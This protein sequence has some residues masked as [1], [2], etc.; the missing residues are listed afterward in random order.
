MN[1][2][3]IFDYI[4]FEW[5]SV[6]RDVIRNVWVIILSMLVG[7]MGV[8]IAE[9]SIYIPEY[10]STAMLVVNVK[11]SSSVANLNI[12][13]AAEMTEVFSDV[14]VQPS[15]KKKA[16]EK[17]GEKNFDGQINAMVLGETNFLYVSVTSSTPE[18]AYNLLN[19]VL[20]AYPE[21]SENVFSNA[22]IDIVK[23]PGMPHGP[24]NTIT[25]KKTFAVA[26]I[27]A[28]AAFGAIVL[29]SVF[30]DTVKTEEQFE[31]S[32]DAKLVGTIPH[33][34]KKNSYTQLFKKNRTPLLISRNSFLSLNFTES[35]QKI[36]TR[37]EHMK[38][39]EDASVFS[40]VSV[41][42]NEGKTTAA[43][44]IAIMLAERGSKVLILDLD[45][46]K[47]ALNK[48]FD[49]ESDSEYPE[50][51]ELLSGKIGLEDFK[52][53]RF[54]KSSLYIAGNSNRY[55][56]YQEWFKD[57]K[58]KDILSAL[59]EQFDYI[60]VDTA[61]M[62]VDAMVTNI[63]SLTDRTIMVVRNDIVRVSSINDA[64]LTI[65]KVGGNL[66]GCIYNDFYSEF[67]LFGQ[68][69]SSESDYKSGRYYR[70]GRKYKNYG[71]YSN[72]NYIID[73]D[74]LPDD[75]AVNDFS[76]DKNED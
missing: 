53:R 13:M 42:E 29:I 38:S 14:F 68:S 69:G 20:K 47:P 4:S 76:N 18:K 36:V 24:S 30:R 65:K 31:S 46:K 62:S 7:L 33:E 75:A 35:Y 16:A 3:N 51:G 71:Y 17:I 22:V 27:M 60:I 49:I 56:D 57:E 74:A 5:H 52:F 73:D 45:A 48:I 2:K 19:A 64:A 21:I 44:N 41:A 32:V 37:M 67:S 34:K 15:M 25:G 26:A 28:A 40:L 55:P 39:D 58:I 43:A 70:Y 50:L 11:K 10:K 23:S 6:L 66:A 72:Y 63:V 9:H 8:Y 59:K 54:E 12:T 1:E 61:P